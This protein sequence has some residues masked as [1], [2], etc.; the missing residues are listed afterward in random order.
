MSKNE[1][2]L[3]KLRSNPKTLKWT[4]LEKI[5]SYLGFVKLEGNGSRVKFF[6]KD[7]DVLINLHK[8]HPQPELKKYMIN[9]I[10][11]KLTNGGLL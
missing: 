8:P 3:N 4:E 11:E 6:N 2:L 7:C 1:K 5:M 10:I 9:Q